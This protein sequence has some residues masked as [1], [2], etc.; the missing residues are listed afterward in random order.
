MIYPH[1]VQGYDDWTLVGIEPLATSNL[2]H[3]QGQCGNQ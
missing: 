1:A 2:C 3:V